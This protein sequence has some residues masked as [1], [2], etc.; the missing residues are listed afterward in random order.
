MMS[1]F[2]L[3]VQL[4][5]RYSVLDA[6]GWLPFSVVF[7]ICRLSTSNTDPCPIPIETAGSVFD[8]PYALAHGLLTLCEERLE[9]ATK[10][11]EVDLGRMEET[12]KSNSNC[13]SVPSLVGRRRS[14][15]NDLTVFLGCIS[16]KGTLASAWK[17]GERYRIRLASTDPCI[18][19]WACS[20]QEQSTANHG[21]A[22]KLVNSYSYGHATFRVVDNLSFPPRVDTSLRLV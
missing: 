9:D 6:L 18:K 4:H 17:A 2:R 1:E 16:L 21:E 7:G 15:K 22:A 5:S 13:V 11:V 10:W 3:H 20:D 8:V 12:E 19:K 14:W